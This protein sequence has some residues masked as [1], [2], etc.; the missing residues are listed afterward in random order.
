MGWVPEALPLSS[1][2]T[3]AK[4]RADIWDRSLF[5][6]MGLKRRVLVALWLWTNPPATAL[7]LKNEGTGSWIGPKVPSSL[8]AL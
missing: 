2:L 1:A 7:H 6:G 5:L 8:L 4:S 3:W